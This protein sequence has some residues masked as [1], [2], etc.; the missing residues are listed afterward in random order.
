MGF[1]ALLSSVT[2]N[3]VDIAVGGIFP[4]AER[5]KAMAFSKSYLPTEQ[6]LL[7]KKMMLRNIK[8]QLI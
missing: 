1:S 2:A 8:L 5:E 6:K 3:K 4:T 7:I